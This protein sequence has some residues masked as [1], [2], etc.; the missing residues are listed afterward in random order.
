MANRMKHADDIQLQALLWA[1]EDSAEFQSAEAHVAECESCQSRLE[2]L[3]GPPEIDAE[4]YD[5][6]SG[7]PWDLIASESMNAVPV[8][9]SDSLDPDLEFLESA[10]HPELLG[11][12]GRYAVE[13]VIGRGGMGIVLKAHDSE[14]NRP[15]AVKVL[16]KHLAYNGT[17]RLRFARESRAAAAVVH[18]HVVAIHNVETN[19]NV[20]FM[21]MQFVAGESLQSRVDRNGP[22]DIKELLRVGVQVASGLAAAHEQGVIH[23]DIKPANILLEMGVERALL[24]DFGLARTVDDAA[25]TQTGIIAGTPHY[26]SPEQSNGQP[27]D[28]RSDL[29]SL[30]SVLYFMATGYPPFRA[31]RAMGVLNRI[32]HDRQKPLWQ[33][34]ANV[35]DEFSILVDRLLEKQ[36]SK[37]FNSAEAVRAHL[38]TQLAQ[39]QQPRVNVL[40]SFRRTA[41]RYPKQFFAS[42]LVVAAA[43]ALAV[44]MFVSFHGP[45]GGRNT[46]ETAPTATS[47]QESLPTEKSRVDPANAPEDF[48]VVFDD[49][50]ERLKAV[51]ESSE[52]IGTVDHQSTLQ[53]LQRRLQRLQEFETSESQYNTKENQ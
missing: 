43:A 39:I 52:Y 7:Y 40:R 25:L 18:E 17:A 37:R 47:T 53:S 16:A 12:L 20:P 28:H 22:L 19:F 4:S 41:M 32:C 9:E 3:S 14:L 6:L 44:V 10:S 27:T 30:G 8:T 26:M 5:L 36:P 49:L 35:P 33:V 34:N 42:S 29:F 50:R 38:V 46:S 13:R 45:S 51:N 31:E 1:D 48:D 21:V 23:R 15:V 24:T 2:Q 11:M